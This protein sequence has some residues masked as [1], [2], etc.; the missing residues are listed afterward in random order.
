MKLQ[1]KK[2]KPEWGAPEA[3]RIPGAP[4]GEG[5]DAPAPVGQRHWPPT[6]LGARKTAGGGN[7]R[8]ARGRPVRSLEPP[9]PRA[10]LGAET[11]NRRPGAPGPRGRRRR[12]SP[13]R[14]REARGEPTP[15]PRPAGPDRAGPGQR[16]RTQAQRRRRRRRADAGQAPEVLGA[17]ASLPAWGRPAVA[18]VAT[19]AGWYR[20]LANASLQPSAPISSVTRAPPAPTTAGG[21]RG[22]ESAYWRMVKG[23]LPAFAYS[24]RPPGSF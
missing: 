16:N 20:P 2:V 8:Q 11:G 7:R 6:S 5:P 9:P 14:S 15:P 19:G 24:R 21:S 10:V 22:E 1:F 13:G 23:T 12:R 17:A 4:G 3:A 18:G